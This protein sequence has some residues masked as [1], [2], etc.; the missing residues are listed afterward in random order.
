[1][2]L[3]RT[4]TN[5]LLSVRCINAF[6]LFFRRGH[7]LVSICS[8]KKEVILWIFLKLATLFFLVLIRSYALRN[9]FVEW[10]TQRSFHIFCHFLFQSSPF[11]YPS[12]S[13][14]SLKK[15]SR[16]CQK[17]LLHSP[18]NEN[19]LSVFHP[20]SFFSFLPTSRIF[21]P[22]LIHS[23]RVNLNTEWKKSKKKEGMKS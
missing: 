7:D 8:S 17:K 9:K 1:M 3:T 2:S 13:L 15:N 10:I 19:F 21:S 6:P 11:F 12:L 23:V 22:T 4:S 18:K 14:L 5:Y 16:D 20:F